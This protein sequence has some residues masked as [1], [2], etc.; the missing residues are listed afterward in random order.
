M[1]HLQPLTP[2]IPHPTPPL[3]VPL[4]AHCAGSPE[5]LSIEAAFSTTL[6]HLQVDE[7]QRVENGYVLLC[8]AGLSACASLRNRRCDRV[9][10][11]LR[12]LTCGISRVRGSSV[13]LCA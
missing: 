3:P 5:Y 12:K 7:I 4:A 6:A 8:P 13:R 10:T 9:D 2:T 11:C 1:P